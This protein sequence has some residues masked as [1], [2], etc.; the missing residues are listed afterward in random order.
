MVFIELKAVVLLF[1][2]G[3][4]KPP[5][6]LVKGVIGWNVVLTGVAVD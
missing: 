6:N 3:F 5:D 4:D 2:V 1:A